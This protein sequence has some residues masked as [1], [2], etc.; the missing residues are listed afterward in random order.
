MCVGLKA[1]STHAHT[2]YVRIQVWVIAKVG[3]F[4]FGV[5]SA[6][7]SSAVSVIVYAIGLYMQQQLQEKGIVLCFF[8]CVLCYFVS[9][10]FLKQ[11]S[12]EQKIKQNKNKEI[13]CALILRLPD[14]NDKYF[15]DVAKV[16]ARM[17]YRHR[18]RDL[19]ATALGI[20]TGLVEVTS[21]VPTT[22]NQITYINSAYNV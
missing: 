15:M 13:R 11:L 4:S 22:G 7:A 3:I 21:M 16:H 20:D 17:G 19:M 9:L 6:L 1:Q 5:V 12:R 8:V 2:T 18:M 10:F 14:T